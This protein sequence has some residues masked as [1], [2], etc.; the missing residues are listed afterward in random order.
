LLLYS[1]H[2]LRSRPTKD[3]DFSVYN[4]KNDIDKIKIVIS[5]IIKQESNDG[6]AFDPSSLSIIEIDE[7]SENHGLR[8]KVI[9]SL[10]NAKINLQLD[11]GF[12]RDP[13]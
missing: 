4:L 6:L 5:D 2:H 1:V 9:T 13:I 10:E 12:G 3:I 7:D 8:I 11:M